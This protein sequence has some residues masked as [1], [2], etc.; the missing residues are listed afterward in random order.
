[1]QEI[2]QCYYDIE[3]IRPQD[4]F[5]LVTLKN[6]YLK[7]GC[8]K[9]N[10]ANLSSSSCRAVSTDIPDPPATSPYGSSLL[11]GPQGYIP[12]PHIP[13]VCRFELF[14]LLLLDHTR[15]SMIMIYY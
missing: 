13:A 10:V 8:L 6:R 5:P 12:Y 14:V 3:S 1:M 2:V 7:S 11:A 15:G 9:I 4:T